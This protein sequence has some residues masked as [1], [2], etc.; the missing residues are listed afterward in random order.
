MPLVL[1]LDVPIPKRGV[2]A[3]W[4]PVACCGWVGQ[5]LGDRLVGSA[6]GDTRRRFKTSF[7]PPRLPAAAGAVTY[8]WE[9]L[10]P[11]AQG[12]RR[13]S[14]GESSGRGVA[15]L[16]GRL[17]SGR[18]SAVLQCSG[19]RRTGHCPARNRPCEA[20]HAASHL[21]SL[22]AVLRLLRAAVTLVVAIQ[23]A[24]SCCQHR[25]V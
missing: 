7:A 16:A 12:G 14:E 2:C 19:L 1:A 4:S 22:L 23:G 17:R 13:S 21:W 15:G 5:R 11:A 3:G 10:F 18:R 25:G 9:D 6:A 24:P 20:F 8:S